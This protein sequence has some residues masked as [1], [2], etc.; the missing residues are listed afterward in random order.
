M[1]GSPFGDFVRKYLVVEGVSCSGHCKS[2]TRFSPVLD[3]PDRTVGL[4][5]CPE[6]YVSRGVYFSEKPDQSWFERYLREDMGGERVRQRDIRKATR[7]GPELGRDAEEEALELFGSKGL[8]EYYWTFY[9][10]SAEENASGTF[11]CARCGKFF[12]KPFSS[13]L[14]ICDRHC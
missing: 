10:R 3:E 1:N 12:V 5:L 13:K 8:T 2:P 14:S 4:Y 6:S 9:P 11:V 7:H